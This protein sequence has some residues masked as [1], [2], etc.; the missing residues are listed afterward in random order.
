MANRVND[1]KKLI[2]VSSSD[3]QRFSSS[4]ILRAADKFCSL[5][6]PLRNTPQ[7]SFGICIR[8][9]ARDVANDGGATGVGC[10]VDDDGPRI[11]VI[12]VAVLLRDLRRGLPV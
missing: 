11:G 3:Y 4:E 7:G 6:L 5:P 8:E 9:N 2:A 10:W 1:S 12:P